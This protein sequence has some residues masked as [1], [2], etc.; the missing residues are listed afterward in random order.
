MSIQK[1]VDGVYTMI[2]EFDDYL[3]PDPE[4][5]VLK[6]I[7]L[8]VTAKGNA[9]TVEAIPFDPIDLKDFDSDGASEILSFKDD[10][11]ASGRAGVGFARQ[12]A[13]ATDTVTDYIP[14]G[15]GALF[16][17][18]TVTVGNKVVFED[19]WDGHDNQTLL[20]KGKDRSRQGRCVGR[21]VGIQRPWWFLPDE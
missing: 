7:K 14:V 3:T 15:S 5:D 10:S 20:P 2:E 21:G 1:K 6:M 12:G 8:K 17:D 9:F 19:A 4:D 13:F 11:L 18:V 16:K